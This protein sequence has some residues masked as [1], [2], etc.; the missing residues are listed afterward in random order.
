MSRFSRAPL[1]LALL[2]ASA[3]PAAAQWSRVTDLPATTMYAVRVVGDTITA[4]GDSTVHVSTDGGVTWT[5]SAVVAPGVTSVQVTLVRDHRLYAATYGNGVFTS[6]DLG[7][8]WQPY[9]TGL[10]GGFFDSQL[11][12][13]D[14][15]FRG[16]S[17]VAATAGS[18]AWVRSVR[19]GGWSPFG[20]VFEPNQSS[21]MNAV[22]SNGTQLFACAG[23]NGNAFWRD[24]GDPDWTITWLDNVGILAGLAP[25]SAIWTGHR[26][27]VGTNRWVFRSATGHEPW[28]LADPGLGTL[29]MTSFAQRGSDLFGAFTVPNFTEIM[30]SRDEG[31][32]WQPL[33]DQPG[34][35]VFNLARRGSDLYAARADGLWKRSIADVSAPGAVPPARLRLALAA[36]QPVGDN[37]RLRI[38]MPGPGRVTLEVFDLA[39]RRVA[40][41]AEAAAPAGAYEVSLDLR[42]LP[43]GVYLARA[44]VAG[45]QAGTRLVRVR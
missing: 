2:L 44:S 1:A 27:V 13:V 6:D 11:D 42:A 36:G 8:S 7:V 21:N 4:S 9:N 34:V 28:S 32:T 15:V 39:G 37:V 14:M 26:W 20:N 45:E 17:L 43:A 5:H 25:L 22:A 24:P 3:S 10:V 16:D 29:F 38:E 35:F 30:T 12:V 23:F 41:L 40:A 33:D 19:G 18:G 31:A